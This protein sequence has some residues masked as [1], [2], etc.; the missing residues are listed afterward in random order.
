M[1]DDGAG[2]LVIVLLCLFLILG[3]CAAPA[4]KP[5]PPPAPT[6]SQRIDALEVRVQTLEQKANR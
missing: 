5:V 1:D 2:C 3:P 4:P 6:V